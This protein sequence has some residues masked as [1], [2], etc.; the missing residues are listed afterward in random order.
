[1]LTPACF[2]HCEKGVWFHRHPQWGHI[3][4]VIISEFQLESNFTYARQLIDNDGA[5]CIGKVR[6]N[7]LKW[8]YASQEPKY[9]KAENY[10]FINII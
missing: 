4:D 9:T 6:F 7:T 10:I 8:K 5:F 1:M 2:V 3:V